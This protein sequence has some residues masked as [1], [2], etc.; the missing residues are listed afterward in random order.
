MHIIFDSPLSKN[1]TLSMPHLYQF[2]MDD[3][4]R[5]LPKSMSMR[6]SM[7]ERLF[8][9]NILAAMY[10]EREV[11]LVNHDDCVEKPLKSTWYLVSYT[12]LQ[13]SAHNSFIVLNHILSLVIFKSFFVYTNFIAFKLYFKC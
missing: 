12:K 10:L 3:H 13:L 9:E 5:S 4:L 1:F 8:M 11:P 7:L 6:K 2:K